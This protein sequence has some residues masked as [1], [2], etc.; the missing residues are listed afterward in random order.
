MY[1]FLACNMS[2]GYAFLGAV[3]ILPCFLLLCCTG[4]VTGVHYIPLENGKIMDVG[5]VKV[6]LIAAT[7]EQL[8][9]DLVQAAEFGFVL[10]A[11]S[12]VI[13]C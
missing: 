2:T 13:E 4:E 6:Q 11:K 5:K 10:L 8:Q 1:A 7:K 3:G 12:Q 9:V